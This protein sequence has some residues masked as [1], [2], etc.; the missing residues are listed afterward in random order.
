MITRSSRAANPARQ[1]HSNRDGGRQEAAGAQQMNTR[2]IYLNKTNALTRTQHTE[3][4]S[5]TEKTNMQ[6][7]D[8]DD[9]DGDHGGLRRRWTTTTTRQTDQTE[10]DER[11]FTDSMLSSFVCEWPS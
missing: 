9:N 2:V 1:Q 8:N 5:E 10:S 6:S 7:D 4:K 11:I 3:N